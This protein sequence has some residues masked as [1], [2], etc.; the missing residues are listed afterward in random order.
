M[1]FPQSQNDPGS[2]MFPWC[3]RLV[4]VWCTAGEESV[5]LQCTLHKV[6]PLVAWDELGFCED[7]D[8]WFV[9][10]DMSADNIVVR[11]EASAVEG[12]DEGRGSVLAVVYVASQV[13]HWVLCWVLRLVLG[14]F[15]GG[16]GMV[17]VISFG[18]SLH[19]VGK[20]GALLVFPLMH[21]LGFFWLGF[22]LGLGVCGCF[23]TLLGRGWVV[24]SYFL[25]RHVGGLGGCG[26]FCS[27]LGVA[28]EVV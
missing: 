27:P 25:V 15:T 7:N 6:F 2:S 11:V 26:C 28:K 23:A 21:W 22:L 8:I 17:C 1:V 12:Y 19:Q 4:L 18:L 5:A 13:L 14:W 9:F 20:D 24:F 3:L 16:V 10:V